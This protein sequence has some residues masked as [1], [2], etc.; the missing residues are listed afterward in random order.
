M[1]IITRKMREDDLSSVKKIISLAFGTFLGADNPQE[2]WADL[3]YS[4]RWYSSPDTAFVAEVNKQVIGS[5]F[6]TQWGQHS[7]LGPLTVHP[8][9]WNK[10]VGQKLMSTG[11]SCLG[12][13]SLSHNGLFTFAHSALHINLYQKFSYWPGDLTAIMS[14]EISQKKSV[15]EKY[16]S[17]SEPAKEQFLI[18]SCLLSVMIYPGL[19]LWN[20]IEATEHNKLGDT[21][22]IYEFGEVSAFAICH[23]GEG[24]EAGRGKCY[25]KFAHAINDDAAT[26]IQKLLD[27]CETY[28]LSEGLKTLETGVNLARRESYNVL[29]ENGFKTVIQGVAMHQQNNRAYNKQGVF[30]FDDWR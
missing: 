14:K 21:I 17:L 23:C 19:C 7:F 9:M 24:T 30:V 25:I 1:H 5:V 27:A 12:K 3:D 29:K 4:K 16:S 22:I 28:A 13:L 20:E 8:S 2:F 15:Y 11:M 10:G 18:S 6:I 26:S